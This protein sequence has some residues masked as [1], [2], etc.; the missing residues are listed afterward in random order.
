MNHYLKSITDI[1]R[2]TQTGDAEA[3]CR[4]ISKFEI[5]SG[6]C[7]DQIIYTLLLNVITYRP[8]L[9]RE[10]KSLFS[11]WASAVRKGENFFFGSCRNLG[12]IRN[13]VLR[14][15]INKDNNAVELLKTAEEAYFGT[16]Y[17]L[18][19][20]TFSEDSEKEL[21][22]KTVVMAAHLFDNCEVL[23]HVAFYYADEPQIFL[24]YSSL[25][26]L[27]RSL[28]D[29]EMY[30][31]LDRLYK[32]C[33]NSDFIKMLGC[34]NSYEYWDKNNITYI[35]SLYRRY[36]S[37]GVVRADENERICELISAVDSDYIRACTIYKPVN[38]FGAMFSV[39][40]MTIL[41][42]EALAE[43]GFKTNDLSPLINTISYERDAHELVSAITGDSP[44]IYITEI[45]RADLKNERVM[46][47]ISEKKAAV[48]FDNQKNGKNLM[49]Y[50]GD[51]FKDSWLKK[52]PSCMPFRLTEC[53][54]GND[55]LDHAINTK[56]SGFDYL[57][58]KIDFTAQQLT[59]LVDM[60][61]KY[62]NLK[63]LNTVRRM[64]DEKIKE[65]SI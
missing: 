9:L 17:N 41:E 52:L 14:A 43:I 11:E 32:A 38:C 33:F 16:S 55:Y 23:E 58:K 2:F 7:I 20:N 39:N 37:K 61:I 26:L 60:C 29:R 12:M 10:N 47:L 44:F 5:T 45:A 21:F 40:P 22:C 3:L 57:C 34:C 46:Q 27:I 25:W 15:I 13:A 65:G 18:A 30:I 64:L 53:V 31:E 63:A 51:I 35:R 49:M 28:T 36:I 56:A 50:Y 42:L 59:E 24:K 19:S 8:E 6:D 1:N 54:S 4:C 62:N 48:C